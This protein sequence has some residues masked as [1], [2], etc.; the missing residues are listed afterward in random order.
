[1]NPKPAKATAAT[2]TPI[3]IN[4]TGQAS[5]RNAGISIAQNGGANFNASY[6]CT[7]TFTNPPG[8]PF[9]NCSNNTLSLSQGHNNENL[10]GSATSGT[11]YTY[12]ISAPPGPRT[13]TT[14]QFDITVS[15]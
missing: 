13:P 2:P 8:C 5:P 1:M 15:S 14:D 10:S 12:T 7:L 3:T 11:K 9:Q 6:A 4:A